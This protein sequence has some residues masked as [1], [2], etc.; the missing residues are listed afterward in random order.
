MQRNASRGFSLLEFSAV[1]PAFVA[2]IIAGFDV[3]RYIAAHN[4]VHEG[5]KLG[6]RCA[7]T[8]DSECTNTAAKVFP[9]R[10]DVWQVPMY[11]PLK[12]PIAEAKWLSAPRY[13]YQLTVTHATSV[14]YDLVGTLGQPIVPEHSYPGRVFYFARTQDLP[15]SVTGS[16][17]NYVVHGGTAH[18]IN[19]FRDGDGNHRAPHGTTHSSNPIDIGHISFV[20]PE[21]PL[22]QGEERKFFDG[23]WPQA[24]DALGCFFDGENL[25]QRCK[26]VWN[27]EIIPNRLYIVDGKPVNVVITRD[28][29]Y[30][31]LVELP[32]IATDWTT[33][34]LEIHGVSNSDV[35]VEGKLLIEMWNGD[36][37]R[38][39]GGQVFTGPGEANFYP[40]GVPA[41]RVRE[42]DNN[43]KCHQEFI[44]H[45]EIV[46]KRGLP[47]DLNFDLRKV[48]GSGDASWTL[49]SARFY[50]VDYEARATLAECQTKWRNSSAPQE[51][52]AIEMTDCNPANDK[53]KIRET[54]WP[55]EKTYIESNTRQTSNSTL[56]P[57]CVTRISDD[58]A[59]LASRGIQPGDGWLE[60]HTDSQQCPNF[61]D[62][63][64]CT[65][66][67]EY[68]N[69]S[70]SQ[71][72]P[73]GAC[74]PPPNAL[75][76][77]YSECSEHPGLYGPFPQAPETENCESIN[78]DPRDRFKSLLPTPY[79]SYPSQ[80][81]TLTRLAVPSAKQG[82]LRDAHHDPIFTG[83][84]EPADVKAQNYR[85]QCAELAS[86]L[87]INSRQISASTDLEDHQNEWL[88]QTLFVAST[89][90]SAIGCPEAWESAVRNEVRTKVQLG[91]NEIIP[92]VFAKMTGLGSVGET[93][94]MYNPQ[95]CIQPIRYDRSLTAEEQR[96][97]L[98]VFE[99]ATLPPECLPNPDLACLSQF[100]NFKAEDGGGEVKLIESAVKSHIISTV[101]GLYPG[102]RIDC[103]NP[104]DANCLSI[105]VAALDGDENV[106]VIGELS[107]P[108]LF[109]ANNPVKIS[110]SDSERWEGHYVK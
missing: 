101:T 43:A 73:L 95:S 10:F 52:S 58:N 48:S 37:H 44:L 77:I 110:Y 26:K 86:D 40:R 107:V 78:A 70:C 67:G 50:N 104:S 16:N 45:Q 29:Q 105:K 74:V 54:G 87:Q 94:I 1:L 24:R 30:E 11:E 12:R 31:G 84:T 57:E 4:A 109:L 19:D 59:Y 33:I 92:D 32:N 68:H 35:G 62:S 81:L 91:V 96:K 9:S 28:H 72:L 23:S 71:Y 97:Y 5:V 8:T 17:G 25:D 47:V 53:L 49:T 99:E 41:S 6:L 108:M 13:D 27:T 98:G 3:T 15:T 75:N 76:P 80:A 39:L 66:D 7:Y 14:E 90:M 88:R 56:P 42:C 36:K 18:P 64:A 69:Y 102:T 61:H 79:N 106:R 55:I 20:V 46:V 65:P 51:E 85:Y 60:R 83:D 21:L 38:K 34:A 103:D 22:P 82:E 63:K 93:R 89:P 100:R 2:L